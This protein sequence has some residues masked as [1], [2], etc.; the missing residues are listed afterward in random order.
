MCMKHWGNDADR[1]EHNYSAK[2]KPV[3]LQ[4]CLT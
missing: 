4:L 3:P 2:E 1:E